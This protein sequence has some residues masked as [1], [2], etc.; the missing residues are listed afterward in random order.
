MSG[1]SHHKIWW[2]GAGQFLPADVDTVAG[3]H[4]QHIDVLEKV[5]EFHDLLTELV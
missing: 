4:L 5:L 3:V 1:K 2:I